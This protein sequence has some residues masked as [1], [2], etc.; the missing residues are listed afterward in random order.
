MATEFS[1]R[2]PVVEVGMPYPTF[3]TLGLRGIGH[4]EING[5]SGTYADVYLSGLSTAKI[6]MDDLGKYAPELVERY[7]AAF[8]VIKEAVDR[9][10]KID[11]AKDKKRLTGTSG[12]D[13]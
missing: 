5:V 3:E 1:E 12:H 8:A 11:L 7:H 9:K 4:D 6:Y 2:P 13:D 10:L